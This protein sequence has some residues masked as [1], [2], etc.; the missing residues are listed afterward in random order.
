MYLFLPISAY[1]EIK[2]IS[3]DCIC[4]K[5]ERQLQGGG[6]LFDTPCGSNNNIDLNKLSG[7]FIIGSLTT[8]LPHSSLTME[9][10]HRIE[11]KA[12][13]FDENYYDWKGV[14]SIGK[15]VNMDGEEVKG[16]WWQEIKFTI[17]RNNLSSILESKTTFYENEINTN[18]NDELKKFF[19]EID[20]GMIYKTFY[21]CQL[22]DKKI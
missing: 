10:P 4:Q 13:S 9:Q 15:G 19:K 6:K 8:N 22:V 20:D 18:D 5:S 7:T 11:I 17:N 12:N 2:K 3:I 16:M 21:S 1:A 14:F